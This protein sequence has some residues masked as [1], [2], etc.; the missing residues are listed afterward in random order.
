MIQDERLK[1]IIRCGLDDILSNNFKG[2]D[3]YD[4]CCTSY[5]FLQK[6]KSTRL[7]SQYFNKFSPINLRP[8]FGI[9]KQ[10]FPQVL[11]YFGLTVFETGEEKQYKNEMD[12]AV[13]FLL[14]ESLFEKYGYHCWNSIG[15]PLQMRN[16][17]SPMDIPDVVGG[18]LIGRFLLEYYKH[19]KNDVVLE[20]I[21]SQYQFFLNELLVDLGDEAFIRYRPNKPDTTATYNASLLASRFMIHLNHYLGREI[22]VQ[23][24]KCFDFVV[25]K[26]QESGVWYYNINLKDGGEKE[27]V[28]FHQGFVLDC[29]LDFIEM[30]GENKKYLNAYHKGLEFYFE[31]QF[32]ENGQGFYRYPKK[33]PVNIHNQSQGIITFARAGKFNLK[34][35]E[36]AKTIA[37]WT[38]ENMYDEKE[39][40]FYYL[41]YPFC[42]NKIRYIRWNDANML[43]ALSKLIN[44]FKSNGKIERN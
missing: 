2:F 13:Q 14:R 43:L 19:Y 6:N 29:I 17:Y 32:L 27:Q 23:I 22:P 33:W 18:S 35:L 25:N 20:A 44:S 40:Y 42:T 8:L 15:F 3:P 10:V 24:K 26:Q 1:N 7:F 34:Y 28:D 30:N 38:T 21:E 41:K 5:S 12:R 39:G 16:S 31:K 37:G 4:G 36:F 11:A 9:K